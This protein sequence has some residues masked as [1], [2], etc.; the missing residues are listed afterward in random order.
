MA[1]SSKSGYFSLGRLISIILAIIPVTNWICGIITRFTRGH[2][3]AGI[4]NI[5]FVPV[6]YVM[7]LI[8]M[9]LS[10]KLLFA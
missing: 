3:I 7:D 5:F 2:I 8:T 4:L 6:F 10:G 9:I 1:K